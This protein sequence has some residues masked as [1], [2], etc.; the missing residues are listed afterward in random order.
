M[1]ILLMVVFCLVAPPLSA[2]NEEKPAEILVSL[3]TKGNDVA[4]D[5]SSLQVPFGKTIKLVFK[6]EADNDSEILHNICDT[7]ARAPPMRY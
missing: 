4:F 2:K 5:T 1:R 3:S 7:K 6:N